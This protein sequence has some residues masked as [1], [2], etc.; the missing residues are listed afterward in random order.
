MYTHGQAKGGGG[1]THRSLRYI[2]YNETKDDSVTTL[3]RSE[4]M[5]ARRPTGKDDPTSSGARHDSGP[6]RPAAGGGGDGGGGG[7][8]IGGEVVVVAP[9]LHIIHTEGGVGEA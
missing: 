9:A 8:G 4:E 1:Q 2:D 5:K 7:A 3:N 6:R